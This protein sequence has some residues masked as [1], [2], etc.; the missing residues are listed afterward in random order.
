M[1]AITVTPNPAVPGQTVNVQGTG[2]SPRQK[3]MLTTVDANGVES[4]FDAANKP[5]NINRPRPDG[6]FGVGINVPPTEGTCRVRAYSPQTTIA[7]EATVEVWGDMAA[8]PPPAPVG[9]M[10][11]G[12]KTGQTDVSASLT[13]F[14]NG[15]PE[16]TTGLLPAG[17]FRLDAG[18]IRLTLK[19]GVTV[20]GAGRDQ[21]ELFA[22]RLGVTQ[23]IIYVAGGT[24]LAFRD[25]KLTGTHPSPGV[26]FTD[27]RE[28]QAGI[29]LMGVQ[30]ATIE[31]VYVQ[32]NMGDSFGVYQAGST[33][34]A[35]IV[36][37]DCDGHGAGRM[38]VAVTAGRRV[39]VERCR[40][41][42][43]PWIALEVE[44]DAGG[45]WY[46][47]DVTFQDNVVTGRCKHLFAV[48]MVGGNRRIKCLRN[49]VKLGANYGIWSLI[50]PKDGRRN[51]D[52]EF[53]GN[54]GETPFAEDPGWPAPG[55]LLVRDS[56]NVIVRD[57][58]QPVKAGMYGI[59]RQGV[60]NNLTQERNSFPGAV[61][62]VR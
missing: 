30:G 21:T 24:R 42:D 2:F 23:E 55:V 56:D 1:S 11:N 57:N 34:S 43:Q 25:F 29:G 36:I 13:A 20:A 47:E 27:G 48:S 38:G 28:F 7:A 22:T 3:F 53:S 10:F 35:D 33:P 31:R 39:L 44:P 51:T 62:V 54:V 15:L 59:I 37:R 9:V 17:R 4:G 50:E 6:T 18:F 49:T 46:A 61:A 26:Y 12:D 32:R 45:G 5:T 19:P 58:V 8:P 60:V 41:S 40:F 16:N 52:V 14:L